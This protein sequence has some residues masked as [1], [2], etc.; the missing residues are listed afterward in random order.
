MTVNLFNYKKE[1]FIPEI[2]EWIGATSYLAE[3]KDADICLFV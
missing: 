1:E 3:V 2:T